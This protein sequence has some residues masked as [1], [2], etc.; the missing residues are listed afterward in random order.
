MLTYIERQSTYS[1]NKSE[2]PFTVVY[3]MVSKGGL[4]NIDVCSELAP[5]QVKTVADAKRWAQDFF[6][7]V[8]PDATDIDGF[9]LDR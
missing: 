4:R 6:D 3:T 7:D 8:A 2:G 9:W 5:A 1:L